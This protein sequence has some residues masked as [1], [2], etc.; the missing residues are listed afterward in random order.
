[1]QPAKSQ[2]LPMGGAVVQDRPPL[3][4]IQ[5]VSRAK[6]LGIIFGSRGVVGVDWGDR[7]GIVR[8]RMQKISRPPNLSAFGRAFAVNGYALSTL[9]YHAQFTGVLPS[10][11]S[12]NL[13]RWSAA[14]V[15]R[16]L[17]PEDSLRRPPGIPTDC[18]CGGLQKRSRSRHLG[19]PLETTGVCPYT[20]KQYDNKA[21]GQELVN[22]YTMTVLHNC[23]RSTSRVCCAASVTVCCSTTF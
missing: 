21:Q 15:D 10:E 18:M 4:G 9:L 5:V 3:A 1:M 19:M 8:Q 14:L 7:M 13:V 22:C 12:A 20:A 23:C 2:L 17:G 6:S 11:H 16:G